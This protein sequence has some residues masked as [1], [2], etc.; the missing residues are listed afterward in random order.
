MYTPRAIPLA[1]TSSRHDVLA[2]G[3]YTMDGFTQG[4]LGGQDGAQNALQRIGAGLRKTGAGIALGAATGA[5]AAAPVPPALQARVA[6][7]SAPI[8]PLQ[9]L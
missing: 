1:A 2:L 5:V 9:A 3:G 6:P 8:A 4:L 7:E